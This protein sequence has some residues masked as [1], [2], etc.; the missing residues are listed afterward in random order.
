[1]EATIK[2]IS[3]GGAF[4]T[5]SLSFFKQ[6]QRVTIEN[7]ESGLKAVAEVRWVA[8]TGPKKGIGVQFI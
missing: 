5:G 6:G 3:K 2:D 1:M 8:T 4:L 7:P